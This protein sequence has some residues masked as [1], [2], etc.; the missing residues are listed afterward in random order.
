M[1]ARFYRAVAWVALTATSAGF[2]APTHGT[3]ADKA[4]DALTHRYI[5]A[6][7]RTD[8]VGAT[9]L[10]DHSR[11]AQ[12]PDITA[13]GRAAR[14]AEWDAERDALAHINRHALSRDNQVDAALLANDLNYRLWS[15]RTLQDWAWNAQSYN[16]IAASSLYL[17]AARDFAPWPQ[18]LASA[19]ARMEAIP[20]LLLETRRQLVAQRVPRVFAETVARQNAGITEIAEGML[21]PHADTLDPAARA[22]FDAALAGLKAA[23]TDQQHWLETVLIPRAAGDFRLGPKLYDEKM[24]FALQSSLTRAVLKAKATQAMRD[25][26]AEM[27]SLARKVLANRADAPPTPA[28]PSAAQQQAAIEAALA[29]TYAQ[30]PARDALESASRAALTEATDFVRVHGLVTMPNGPVRIITM[31]KFQQGNA[32]AYDDPPGPL[33]RGQANFFAVSPIPDSWSDTQAASF[34]AEYNNDMIQDLA[35]H[36]AMPGHYLQLDHANHEP[37][38]VRA[39]LSSGPFVEGWAVYGEGLM[40]EQG[41]LGH[42]PLYE[43]TVLKMRLR[44]VTNTLLDIGIQTEGMTRERAMDL[45]VKGAFQ[46]ERE[47]SGKWLRASLSSVQLLSYYT[48]YEEHMAL[49]AEAKRR[50]GPKFTLRRYHDAVLAHGSPPIRYVRE[51]MFDLPIN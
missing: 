4:F 37:S 34:L 48:G 6:L 12:L 24:T 43:L 49:R 19:T 45:M 26:R 14:D 47:A 51:L 30:H 41:Y 40:K 36:E 28:Q 44:S 33:E 7:V 3:A 2:G 16:D 18:R 8:P 32:V 50:W 13:A 1:V 29:L 20:A 21:A 22:K 17:L 11:D 46:Q 5:A 38:I 31:P 10:G 42:D 35:I 23:V 25:V 15:D 9:Q 39:I 27:Y